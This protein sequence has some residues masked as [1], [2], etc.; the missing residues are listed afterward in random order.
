M[1]LILQVM[2]KTINIYTRCLKQDSSFSSDTTLHN[3]T[4]TYSNI[5]T[6][7]SATPHKSAS[8]IIVQAHSRPTTPCSQIIQSYD[9]LFQIQNLFSRL[10]SS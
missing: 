9:T 7:L 2:M 3:K 5:K 8:A 10:L 4:E 6:L 1:I